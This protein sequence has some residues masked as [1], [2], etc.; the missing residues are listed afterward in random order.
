MYQSVGPVVVRCEGPW[1]ND[2]R[3]LRPTLIHQ[4]HSSCAPRVSAPLCIA[5]RLSTASNRSND[6]ITSNA[7]RV[8][9][10]VTATGHASYAPRSTRHGRSRKVGALAV[11]PPCPQC[12]SSLTALVSF[13][14]RPP[15]YFCGACNHEWTVERRQHARDASEERRHTTGTPPGPRTPSVQT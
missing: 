12:Q 15:T 5:R 9:R 4:P 2:Q 11:N 14:Y 10:S 13:C 7:G 3:R 8:A 1:S 6:G